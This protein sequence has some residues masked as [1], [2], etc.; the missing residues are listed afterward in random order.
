M[1][2]IKTKLTVIL[3]LVALLPLIT[4]GI[5]IYNQTT[6][7]YTE[8]IQEFLFTIA[9]SKDDALENYIDATETLGLS[10]A[11]T[12]EMQQYI[13]LAYRSL[14]ADQASEF[15]DARTK[16]EDLLFSVQEAHWGK[17]HHVF[18]IDKSERIVISPNHGGRAVRGTPSS[19]LNED[20]SRN[21]WANQALSQGIPTVSDYSSWIESDHSHQMLF[22]PV[23]DDLGLT[24]AVIGFELQIPYEQEI[25]TENV[26]LG[27]TGRV[28]LATAEGVPIVYQGIENQIPLNTPGVE[29][30]QTKGSSFGRRLN[31]EGV[32]VVDVYLKNDN[33]PWILVAE[34]ET[35]EV[36]SSLYSIQITMLTGLL[37]TFA[38]IIV[39]AIL[40][41]NYMV[42]PIN[43]LIK[44]MKAVSLGKVD[45]KV[46]SKGRTD[47]IGQLVDAFNRIMASLKIAMAGFKKN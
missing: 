34:I 22:F 1:N 43:E 31:A 23:K 36:F 10:I 7:I 17:Y 38:V 29:E 26:D 13:A 20:T 41:S 25:L 6:N 15:E 32:E 5:I 44:Q 37:L 45:I 14:D 47:E 9:Q 27:E 21:P 46:D 4:L 2:S 30:A 33:Y 3:L 24:Q 28:F 18:L 16:V 19:H 39:L 12:D 42:N 35:E 8:T 40:F 11:Q